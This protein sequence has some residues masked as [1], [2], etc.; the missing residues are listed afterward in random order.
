MGMLFWGG[1]VLVKLAGP[2]LLGD[3]STAKPNWKLVMWTAAALAIGFLLDQVIHG[4]F[5]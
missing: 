5:L 4:R 1:Y 2:M 3:E